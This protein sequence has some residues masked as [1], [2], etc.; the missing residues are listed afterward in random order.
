MRAVKLCTNEILLFLTGGA[1][2]RS[3]T[4]I[5]AVK[6]WLLFLLLYFYVQMQPDWWIGDTKN[7]DCDT[8]FA[9]STTSTHHQD[10]LGLQAVIFE[11]LGEENCTLKQ[12]HVPLTHHVTLTPRT[13]QTKVVLTTRRASISCH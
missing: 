12:Q 1:G 10:G 7:P 2:K 3:L 9:T 13:H 6:N 5:M 4:C 8:K 11:F